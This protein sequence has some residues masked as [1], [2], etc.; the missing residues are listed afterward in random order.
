MLIKIAKTLLSLSYEN[1]SKK[2]LTDNDNFT[3][4]KLVNVWKPKINQLCNWCWYKH[5]CS[6][7]IDKYTKIDSSV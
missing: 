6:I 3:N 4:K 2:T 1:M 5:S 7:W